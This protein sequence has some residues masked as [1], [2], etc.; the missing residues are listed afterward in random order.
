MVWNLTL[1]KFNKILFVMTYAVVER[2]ESGYTS[3]VIMDLNPIT[4]SPAEYKTV[5]PC[6]EIVFKQI[7][8]GSLIFRQIGLIRVFS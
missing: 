2:E 3:K 4:G 8:V 7:Y 6:K 1:R 5:L